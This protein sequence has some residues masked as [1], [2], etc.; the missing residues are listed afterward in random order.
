MMKSMFFCVTKISLPAKFINARLTQALE[1][2]REEKH[3]HAP[4]VQ[5]LLIIIT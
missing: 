2:F 1:F 3:R 5:S 4:K